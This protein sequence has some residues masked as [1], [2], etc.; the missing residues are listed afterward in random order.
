MTKLETWLCT[1]TG[2]FLLILLIWAGGDRGALRVDKD[3][4]STPVP[5]ARH[6]AVI[7][8]QSID[9][10][11]AGVQELTRLPGIG[12]VTAERIV[13]WRERNGP[14]TSPEDLLYVEGIGEA[15]LQSI[16]EWMED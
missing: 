16:Y 2:V 9:L 14:F 10:N 11:T 4:Q 3:A 13:E 6:T 15:T 12:T 8:S 5:A 1:L 7:V